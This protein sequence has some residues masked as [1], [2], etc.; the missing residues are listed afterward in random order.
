MA[1]NTAPIFPLTPKATWTKLTA[2]NTLTD[3]TGTVPVIFTAGAD[4]GRLDKIR[5]R[6]LGTNVATVVRVFLNNGSTAA[7]ATNNSLIAE[8]FLPATTAA[9]AAEIGPNID[10][11][12]N[13]AIPATYTVMVCI[14]TA[15]SAGWQFTALG[16][17]Y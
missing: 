13:L 1:A 15:V 7:T 3:G 11:E 16:G 8:K 10:I 5:C 14:G 4:G 17:N 12:I 9:N 6:A 2:A